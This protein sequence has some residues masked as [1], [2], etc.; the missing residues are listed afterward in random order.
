MADRRGGSFAEACL[1]H[2]EKWC[3]PCYGAG[4]DYQPTTIRIDK[5]RVLVEYKVI[6]RIRSPGT[7][8]APCH[9]TPSL[10]AL[11]VRQAAEKLAAGTAYTDTGWIVVDELGEPVHPGWYSDEFERCVGGLGSRGLSYTVPGT[12]PSP[13]WRRRGCRSASSASGPGTTT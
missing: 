8:S 3:E 6:E 2:R 1:A 13:L 4:E 7:G 5:T 12:P 10:R 9:S 11:W